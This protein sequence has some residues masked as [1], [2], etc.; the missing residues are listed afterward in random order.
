[1]VRVFAVVLV[2]L[3]P[4]SGAVANCFTIPDYRTGLDRIVCNDPPAYQ[5]S[6]QPD[7]TRLLPQAP[8]PVSIL[9]P[10]QRMEMEE[11]DLRPQ[12]LQE[13]PSRRGEQRNPGQP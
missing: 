5:N 10:Q 4:T 2:A 13:Q 9:T 8:P 6:A 7:W 1:M 12:I 11:L 3:I